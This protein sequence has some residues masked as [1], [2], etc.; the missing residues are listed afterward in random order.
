MRTE[1]L[2][3]GLHRVAVETS[4]AI[5]RVVEPARLSIG[6][7][8]V[9]AARWGHRRSTDIDFFCEPEAYAE[10]DERKRAELEEAL[11][12]V[13]GIEA[14]TL[15]CD[16]IATWCT[17]RDTEVTILPRPRVR[18]LAGRGDSYLGSTRIALQAN[19]EVLYGK[20]VRRMLQAEEVHV[21]DVY[22]VV[23][24]AEHD[25]ASLEAAKEFIGGE[26]LE[27]VA[28]LF[29]GLPPGW[30]RDQ[31]KMLLDPQIELG[32][33]ELG[34]KFLEALR[35]GPGTGEDGGRGR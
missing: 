31:E 30:T 11:R 14:E 29:E 4:T 10:L 13:P 6:G 5:C 35:D 17:V 18:P 15:W 32:E 33:N 27:N 23:Y 12:T 26:T 19:A 21:R 9:L 28:A 7:G 16:P 2:R 25:R 3:G 8:T 22:D 20:I 24:A 1:R 34:V